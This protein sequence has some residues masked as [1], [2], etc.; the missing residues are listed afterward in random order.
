MTT[1]TR[2]GF[3]YWCFGPVL[4][5]LAAVS[6]AADEAQKGTAAVT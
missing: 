3:S 4:T 1:P 5:F 2:G 6:D